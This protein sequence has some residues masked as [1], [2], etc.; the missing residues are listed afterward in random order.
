MVAVCQTQLSWHLTSELPLLQEKPL[1]W[2]QCAKFDF[3]GI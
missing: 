3:P 2:L 1:L